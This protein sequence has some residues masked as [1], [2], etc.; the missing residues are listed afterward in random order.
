[1]RQNVTVSPKLALNS[2]S[3]C[4]SLWGAYVIDIC[5]CTWLY[6]VSLKKNKVLL[7]GGGTRL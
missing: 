7:G 6:L 2:C 1:L 4:L 5:H 3:N